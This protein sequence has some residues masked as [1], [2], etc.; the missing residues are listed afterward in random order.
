MASCSWTRAPPENGRRQVHAWTLTAPHNGPALGVGPL[1]FETSLSREGKGGDDRVTIIGRV[2]RNRRR[3]RGPKQ[4]EAMTL[5]EN[6]AGLAL[7][8]MI[9]NSEPADRLATAHQAVDRH[10]AGFW[11]R[12]GQH[13]V[14]NVVQRYPKVGT[15]DGIA[16]LE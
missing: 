10:A 5:A 14:E 7:F 8:V 13:S 15:L 16:A 1:C 4:P 11:R 2:A 9:G 12:F 6:G 3:P